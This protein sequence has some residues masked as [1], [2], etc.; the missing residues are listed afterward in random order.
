MPDRVGH[1]AEARRRFRV[2]PDAA[3][4][5]RDRTADADHRRGPGAADGLCR[6]LE[7]ALALRRM[8]RANNCNHR[9]GTG[10][11][12]DRSRIVPAR[13]YFPDDCI[14]GARSASETNPIYL[15]YRHFLSI[16][17]QLIR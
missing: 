13:A 6:S 2:E 5:R 8:G 16:D 14:Q 4:G 11:N 3:R 1:L 10:S 17:I 7:L 12:S 15:F 9:L